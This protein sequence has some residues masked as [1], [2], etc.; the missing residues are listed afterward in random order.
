MRASVLAVFKN[1]L[2]TASGALPPSPFTPM[3]G[4]TRAQFQTLIGSTTTTMLEIAAS[5]FPQ[6]PP[7]A[8]MN[9]ASSSLSPAKE[10]RPA[11]TAA[12][13]LPLPH[14]QPSHAR[15]LRVIHS[16]RTAPRAS[17]PVDCGSG[18]SITQALE[19]GC[20]T[21]TFFSAPRS[22]CGCRCG[23]FERMLL[24]S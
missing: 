14:A 18:C 22:S 2:P 1:P 11:R 19:V 4:A 13:A 23:F 7:P 3:A 12:P 15:P 21:G 8:S 6:Q 16:H 17:S 9:N 20:T 24:L 10:M 5:P